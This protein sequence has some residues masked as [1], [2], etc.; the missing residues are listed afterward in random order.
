MQTVD[1]PCAADAPPEAYAQVRQQREDAIQARLEKVR[2]KF[3]VASIAYQ[4][5]PAGGSPAMQ[6]T[7]Q[8]MHS[9]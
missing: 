2:Q 5:V 1:M 3:G 9:N 8:G 6:A 4:P 7:C